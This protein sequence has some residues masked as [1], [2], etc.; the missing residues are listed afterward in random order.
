MTVHTAKA[1]KAQGKCSRCRRTIKKGQQYKWAKGRYT[2]RR[3]WCERCTP[4]PSELTG[5]DKLSRLYAARESVEDVIAGECT[6]ENLIEALNDAATEAREV[7]QEYEDSFNNMPEALANSITGEELTE[8]SGQC[9]S[10]ANALDDAADE[11]D[12]LDWDDIADDDDPAPGEDED[13]EDKPARSDARTQAAD[14]A[15]TALG[16]LEL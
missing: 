13:D 8:K 16:E 9:E 6:K 12:A 1:R 5:S 11:I 7:A 3:V 10:W 15:N 4:R 2:A 14:I